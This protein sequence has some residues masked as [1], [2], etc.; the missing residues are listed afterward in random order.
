[1]YRVTSVESLYVSTPQHM[2]FEF[3]LSQ[4]AKIAFNSAMVGDNLFTCMKC[5]IKC[6]T[7]KSGK[8]LILGLMREWVQK[9]RHFHLLFTKF[10]QKSNQVRNFVNPFFSPK[11]E[12]TQIEAREDPNTNWGVIKGVGYFFETNDGRGTH[13]RGLKIHIAHDTV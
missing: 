11:N 4:M 1:M 6:A 2:N 12:K 10:I 3:L 8:R 9:G 13:I 7:I 5:L